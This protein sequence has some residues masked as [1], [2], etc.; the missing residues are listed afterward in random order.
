MRRREQ[1]SVTQQFEIGSYKCSWNPAANMVYKSPVV[2][3]SHKICVD[4]KHRKPYIS[5]GPFSLTSIEHSWNYG[6]G[7]YG[8]TGPNAQGQTYE[9]L[10][11]G[12]I[13]VYPGATNMPTKNDD[14]VLSQGARAYAKFSPL[15]PEVNAGQFLYE[16]RE[17]NL[18]TAQ[19]ALKKFKSLYELA[20]IKT[21][22]KGAAHLSKDMSDAYL[23]YQFGWKPFVTD[24]LKWLRSIQEID[25]KVAKLRA[26]NGKWVRTGGTLFK[27]LTSTSSDG[28]SSF[29]PGVYYPYLQYST[30][31]TTSETEIKCWFK[32]TFRYYIPELDDPRWGKLKAAQKLYGL[33]LTPQLVWQLTPWTWLA[34]W[35][36]NVGSLIQNLS[37][38]ARDNLVSNGAWL[39]HRTKKTTTA[40]VNQQ[41]RTLDTRTGQTS[42][43]SQ[44]LANC[45]TV[46]YIK[47]RVAANPFGFSASFPEIDSWKASILSALGISK[48]RFPTPKA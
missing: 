34:G 42:S 31:K 24:L 39:M 4:E 21:F 38:Q 46:Q 14:Y 7:K 41:W 23:A 13:H 20:R 18:L 5:G 16:L 1:K 12:G 45:T 33:E 9:S 3:K 26:E 48:L 37:E 36:S 35:F 10:Y 11:I 28:V 6:H 47:T 15:A 29:Y 32:G 25:Q 30:A 17:M 19:S 8:V 44:V 2:F 43:T 22:G 40:S 27:D